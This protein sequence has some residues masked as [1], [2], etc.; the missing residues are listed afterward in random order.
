MPNSTKKFNQNQP[1]GNTFLMKFKMA[2]SRTMIKVVV[3]EV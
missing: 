1:W 2:D 3:P